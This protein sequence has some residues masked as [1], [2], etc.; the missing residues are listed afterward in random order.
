MEKLS[1]SKAQVKRYN[2][3]AIAG[4]GVFFLGIVLMLFVFQLAYSQF[5]APVENSSI[6]INPQGGE[7]NL[8]SNLL[9][10]IIKAVFL[11]VMG[12]CGSWVSSR[13]L[14]LYRA[15]RAEK[16]KE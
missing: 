3:G 2:T 16:E 10:I 14:Q 11:F 6:Q 1:D 15:S 4:L 5:S 13:G 9:A 7:I 8:Q 12:F